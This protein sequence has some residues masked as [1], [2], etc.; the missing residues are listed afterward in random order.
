MENGVPFALLIGHNSGQS[1]E[2][3]DNVSL[4]EL[5]RLWIEYSNFRT[6]QGADKNA[7]TLN[8][9]NYSKK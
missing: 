9:S 5:C 6:L 3:A 4:L 8:Y 2:T 7:Q 1:F